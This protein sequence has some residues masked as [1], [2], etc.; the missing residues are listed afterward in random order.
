MYPLQLTLLTLI[1]EAFMALNVLLLLTILGE[2]YL[3][4]V[5]RLR[6]ELR[7]YLKMQAGKC[8]YVAIAY[9]RLIGVEYLKAIVIGIFGAPFACSLVFAL[10]LRYAG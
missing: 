7:L 6:P 2:M 9:S 4:R 3:F 8:A 5:S 10:V 1:S